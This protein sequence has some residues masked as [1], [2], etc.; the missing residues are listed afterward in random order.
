VSARYRDSVARVPEPSKV[1]SSYRSHHVK[2]EPGLVDPR[3]W[4]SHGQTMGNRTKPGAR[5]A[6]E[7]AVYQVFC[8]RTTGFEPATLTLG[9]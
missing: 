5:T 3:P 1:S 6:L 7:I 8:E 9:R 4:A 2:Y